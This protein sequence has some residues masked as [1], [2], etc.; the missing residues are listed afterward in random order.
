[1]TTYFIAK[2]WLASFNEHNIENLL[3]LYDG[4]AKH[5]S[6]KLKMRRPETHGIISGKTAMRTWWQDAFDRLPGLAYRELTITANDERVF[7]E[8]QRIVPGEK[9]MNVAEVL[10]IKNGL[11]VASRVYHS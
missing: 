4:E 9:E 8:Y 5:F 10:D 7:M 3:A 2:K 1:M 11:I 6:P